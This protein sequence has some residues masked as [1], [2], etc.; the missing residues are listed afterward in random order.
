MASFDNIIFKIL[1]DTTQF[2][3][4][5]GQA[6]GKI[7]GLKNVAGKL[8]NAFLPFSAAATGALGMS[9]K[10]AADFDKSVVSATRALDLSGK[11]VENFKKSIQGVQKDLKYQFSTKELA[12]VAVEAAKLGIAKN[13]INDFVKSISKIAVATDQMDKIGELTNDA[14]KVASVFKFSAKQTDT[15]LNAVNKLDDSAAVT[16]PDILNYTKRVAGIGAQ[17]KLTAEELAAY[18][19]ALMGAGAKPQVAATFMNK[20]LTVL[21]AAE[22][23]S[24]PATARLK[25]LGWTTKEL[26]HAFDK[27]ASGTITEFMTRVSKLDNVSQKNVLGKIFGQEHVDTAM[28]LVQQTKELAKYRKMAADSTGN[29]TKAQ[30]EFNTAAASFAGQTAQFKNQI[31]EIGV[32]LG[33]ILLPGILSITK[34]LSPLLS[35]LLAI[36]QT[37]PQVSK[38]IVTALGV[39]ALIAPLGMLVT[40]ILSLMSTIGALW[41][42]IAGL[43]SGGI[44]LTL[45]MQIVNIASILAYSVIPAIG[46]FV[47]ASAPFIAAAVAIGAAAYAIYANWSKIQPVLVNFINTMINNWNTFINVLNNSW[48]RFQSVWNAGMA[49]FTSYMSERVTYIQSVWNA[50]ISRLSSLANSFFVWVSNPSRLANAARLFFPMQS[51]MASAVSAMSS[52]LSR[53]YS[54]VGSLGSSFGNMAY[55]WGRSL[56]QGFINGIYSMYSSVS[57]AMN[58]FTSQV[59][60]YLPHSDAKKGALSTLTASGQAFTKTFL[61]GVDAGGID[62]LGS[63]LQT[64]QMGS[65]LPSVTATPASTPS[66]STTINYSPTYTIDTKDN[67]GLLDALKK[68]DREL[69]DIINRAISRIDRTAY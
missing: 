9:I 39:V 14:A 33:G 55:G 67:G 11:E 5:L 29:A 54:W 57:A 43:F 21:G 32:Q 42:V 28:L 56:L 12:D 61:S 45:A 24:K 60:Q 10:M 18:G 48:V 7:T 58:N 40:G 41:G 20:F 64:P 26:A 69:V 22:N 3:S 52:A 8:S 4:A 36:V 15:F 25:E 27:D 62:Q 30:N 49:A 47:V 2:I 65:M 37:N 51:G 35:K 66:G 59:S 63:M 44:F 16:A 38:M 50:G 68:R 31:N 19:T 6:E 1:A 34:E 53:F 23:L 13:N 17:S 46:A